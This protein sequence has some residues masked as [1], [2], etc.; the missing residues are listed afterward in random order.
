M[1]HLQLLCCKNT[2]EHINLD[3]RIS[4]L[5]DNNTHRTLVLFILTMIVKKEVAHIIST[6][7]IILTNIDMDP[8]AKHTTCNFPQST[9]Q[10]L[11]KH[12]HSKTSTTDMMLLL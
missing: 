5:V 9:P 1:Y 11:P 3:G 12:I 10:P 6:K 7:C 2:I 8:Y 4:L